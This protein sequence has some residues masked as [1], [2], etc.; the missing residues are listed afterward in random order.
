MIHTPTG[1]A[2]ALICHGSRWLVQRRASD[3]ELD[4]L[5]EFPGGKIGFGESPESAAEREAKEEAGLL[6]AARMTLPA[7]DHQYAHGLVRLFPVI[8]KLLR[9][10]EVAGVEK[11]DQ[12]KWV[13][14]ESLRILAMPA[15]NGPIVTSLM[16]IHDLE[17]RILKG[18]RS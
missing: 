4:G 15:A 13:D 16:Q 17:Q 5:W 7:V 12:V 9:P 3:D 18:G 2:L 14:W 6:V 8:C 11:M 10:E 1:V